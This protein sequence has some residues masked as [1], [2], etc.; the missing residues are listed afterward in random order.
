MIC[1]KK[2]TSSKLENPSYRNDYFL[3][4]KKCSATDFNKTC[5]MTENEIS[6]A[7]ILLVLQ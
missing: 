3:R 6:K 4:D 5:P 2:K 1:R 7:I